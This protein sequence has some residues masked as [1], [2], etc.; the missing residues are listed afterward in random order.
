M[1]ISLQSTMEFI[2]TTKGKP[3]LIFNGSRFTLNR[4]MDNGVCYWRCAKRTCPARI[5][6]EGNQTAPHNHAVNVVDT[7]VKAIYNDHLIRLSTHSD[8]DSIAQ[9]NSGTI[10]SQ[11]RLP[12]L[13]LTYQVCKTM[14]M[15]RQRFITTQFTQHSVSLFDTCTL[16]NTFL[17][18]QCCSFGCKHTLSQHTALIS[19]HCF[20][21]MHCPYLLL[22]V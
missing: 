11:R 6:T 17:H 2:T 20:F 13:P 21:L 3:A 18:L 5:I 10:E 15:Y 4:R 1:L 19:T 8:C 22:Q 9:E 12:P 7:Q 16:N 14:R